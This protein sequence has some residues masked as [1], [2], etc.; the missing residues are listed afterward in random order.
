[1]GAAEVMAL[2]IAAV[3]LAAILCSLAVAI[4][5]CWTRRHPARHAR[6]SITGVASRREHR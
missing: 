4:A 5:V 2:C 6:R 3:V 1:M